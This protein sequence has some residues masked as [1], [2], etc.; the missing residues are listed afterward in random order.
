MPKIKQNGR[1]RENTAGTGFGNSKSSPKQTSK[2]ESLLKDLRGSSV[3]NSE[4]RTRVMD[5][6][7]DSVTENPEEGKYY[8][9]EYDPKFRDMLKKW[10]QYPLIQLLEKKGGQYLGANLH[11]ITPKQRLSALNNNRMPTPTLHYYIPKRADN[12][13]FEVTS[14]DVE[15]L[16]Q[17]PLEKF[18]NAPSRS[19]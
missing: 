4:L 11:Y 10:D 6:L 2:F 13:F 7:F 14:T 16:S 8:F 1:Q 3:T 19:K 17:L 12:L 15:L 9:F 5:M 18:H